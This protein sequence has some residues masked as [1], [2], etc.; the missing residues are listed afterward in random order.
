MPPPTALSC[1]V[2]AAWLTVSP[3]E[4]VDDEG[5][6]VEDDVVVEETFWEET[7]VD[8]MI[9]DVGEGI[10]VDSVRSDITL[11]T[12]KMINNGTTY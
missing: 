2:N 1:F 3:P 9:D 11:K 12:Y 5:A 10:A 7:V 8:F 4:V 6:V